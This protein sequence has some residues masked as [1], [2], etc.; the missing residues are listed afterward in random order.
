MCS[1]NSLLYS[2]VT[3]RI[4]PCYHVRATMLSTVII[5]IYV[6]MYYV[7]I[8]S[9]LTKYTLSAVRVSTTLELLTQCILINL[10]SVTKP[11]KCIPH[12]IQSFVTL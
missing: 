6:C 1:N 7:C 3:D 5:Y 8:M 11:T 12:I 9:V 10:F 4:V 2:A